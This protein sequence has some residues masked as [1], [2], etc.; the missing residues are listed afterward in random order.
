MSCV[1]EK[2]EGVYPKYLRKRL[3]GEVKQLDSNIEY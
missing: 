1:R 2:V 3:E